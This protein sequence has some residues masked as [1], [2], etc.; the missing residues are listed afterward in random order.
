MSRSMT[1]TYMMWC[2]FSK[3]N[4]T[5]LDELQ[6]PMVDVPLAYLFL[7]PLP[8]LHLAADGNLEVALVL[9]ALKSPASELT[10]LPT[11]ISSLLF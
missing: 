7:L 10:T 3:Y 8:L 2:L 1:T 5:S 6:D 9:P 4:R 11:S